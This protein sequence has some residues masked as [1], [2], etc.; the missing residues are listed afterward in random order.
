MDKIPLKQIEST[1]PT[2]VQNSGVSSTQ[3]D[4]FY[5]NIVVKTNTYYGFTK[6]LNSMR[7]SVSGTIESPSYIRFKTYDGDVRSFL[8]M[9]STFHWKGSTPTFSKNKE[10]L[11]TIHR[12][13]AS[14]ETL[15]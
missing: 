2:Y 8:F 6:P 12:D 1:S 10:Y 15:T 11:I 4:D 5:A 3:D 13:V 9:A 14:L 7:L